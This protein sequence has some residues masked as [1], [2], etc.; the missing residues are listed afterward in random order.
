LT[1][2]ESTAKTN[3]SA[4]DTRFARS[5]MRGQREVKNAY[6]KIC[7]V[8]L[9]AK[10]IDPS[11]VKFDVQMTIPSAI[12]ELAQLEIR[13]AEV[14]LAEKFGALAPREWILKNIMRFSDAQIS[15]MERMRQREEAA[16]AEGEPGTRSRGS[17]AHLQKAISKRHEKPDTEPPLAVAVSGESFDRKKVNADQ[18]WNSGVT[19][20]LKNIVERLE[21]AKSKD[22]AFENRW[23]KMTTILTEIQNQIRYSK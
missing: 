11:R 10:G 14:E 18:Y 2:E 3:L 17:D 9:A 8:H 13:S 19:K 21:E 20:N 4:E 16:G 22:K 23:N 1:Y 12:F 15:E 6:K 7:R 5:T